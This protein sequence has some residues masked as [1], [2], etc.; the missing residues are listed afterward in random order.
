MLAAYKDVMGHRSSTRRGALLLCCA[1]VLAAGAWLTLD[2]FGALRAVEERV[3]GVIDP[4]PAIVRH[5]TG[6][7]V[8]ST[9]RKTAVVWAVGDGNAGGAAAALVQRIRRTRP[10]LFLY[11]GDVYPSG[12]P[13]DFAR[14]YAPTYGQLARRTAPTPGNHDWPEASEGYYPYWSTTKSKPLPSFFALRA[15]GWEILALNSE[16]PHEADSAQLRWL[17]GRLRRP[18]NCRIAFWHR[19]LISAG[20]SHGDQPD[21]APLWQALRG[22]ARIVINGHEHDSQRF[23]PVDGITEF[24]AG[25]GGAGLYS[26]DHRDSRLAFGDADHYA[27]LRLRLRPGV[28]RHA[29]V[30]GDGRI[31]D[32]GTVRCR[33]R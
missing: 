28:A 31:L 4:D 19:P 13:D 23:R 20:T 3:E 22:R 17:R 32:Q 12:T 7:V 21:V 26:L 11:L 33:R 29:F 2:D 25:A 15:A 27:A 18:S 9:Q 24:V 8:P 1:A 14:N 6:D 16:A 30:T 5:P 10:D